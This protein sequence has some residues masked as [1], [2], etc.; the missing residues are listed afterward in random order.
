MTPRMRIAYVSSDLGVPIFG[1]KGCSIH[2]QE[3]L[4][5]LLRGGAEVELFTTHGE[6]ERPQDLESI[7]L[8]AL[9][10]PPKGDPAAREQ[11]ALAGNALLRNEL[12]R[13]GS[14]DL[15][16]ER[17]SLWS[18]AGM[19]FARERHVPGLLEVN[20]PLIDEQAQYRVLVD[21]AAAE[22]SAERAF[23]AATALLAVSDEV[24]AWL[25]SFPAA[26][27]K[28]SVTPNGVRPERFPADLKPSLPSP[29]GTFTVGFVGT[30][31]AWHG[32]SVLVEAFAQLRASHPAARLLVVG[33]GPERERLG[34]DLAQRGL[35]SAAHLTGA[36]AP[37]A[38]PGL[39]AS[40]DIAVAPYPR[41][42]A[43]YFSPLKLFE[44]M[45]AGRAVVASGIGQVAKIIES[46]LNGILVPPGDARALADALAGLLSNPIL[47]SRLGSAARETVLRSYTWD[48]VAARILQLA[49]RTP[50][51]PAH[52]SP[53]LA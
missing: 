16:Y 45:A 5:A 15:I 1:R 41:L 46:G 42:D 38:V 18:F 47:R 35:E 27:G 14:F 53:A 31:K 20:A 37:A 17:Y 6:G 22:R 39:L 10:R 26:R 30:L 52:P 50:A 23:R 44:Y 33:D 21:R 25:E 32:L 9:Q 40:M 4:A 28:I 8:H 36:V 24:A 3:V 43:F 48:E 13:S 12:M 19:E 34:G 11:A 29:A 49:T 51:K 7:A 2:A